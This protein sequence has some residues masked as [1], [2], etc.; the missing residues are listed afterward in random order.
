MQYVKYSLELEVAQCPRAEGPRAL[1]Y[2]QRQYVTY[3]T[4]AVV[5]TNLLHGCKPISGTVA[6]VLHLLT[7]QSILRTDNYGNYILQHCNI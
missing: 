5:I 6:A 1:F 3:C 4:R 7:V 2:F